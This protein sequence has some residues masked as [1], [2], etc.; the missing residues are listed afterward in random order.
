ML[1]AQ[2]IFNGINIVKSSEN[3]IKSKNPHWMKIAHIVEHG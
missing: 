3:C 1:P 2:R